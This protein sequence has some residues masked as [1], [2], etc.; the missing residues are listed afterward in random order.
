MP[1]IRFTFLR[2]EGQECWVNSVEEL[3]PDTQTLQYV[4]NS[5][6]LKTISREGVHIL[7]DRF[8]DSTGLIEDK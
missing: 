1:G 6:H 5:E 3:Q 4:W 2:D 7:L 8:L